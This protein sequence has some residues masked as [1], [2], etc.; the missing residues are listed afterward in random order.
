MRDGGHAIYLL[1]ILAFLSTRDFP[2][3]K[4]PPAGQQGSPQHLPCPPH[5]AKVQENLT[6]RLSARRHLKSADLNSEIKK[7]SAQASVFLQFSS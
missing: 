5:A 1:W 2:L 6:V 3:E 7:M 4:L